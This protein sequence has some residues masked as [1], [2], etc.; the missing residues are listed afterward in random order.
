MCVCIDEPRVV[1]ERYYYNANREAYKFH[2]L[3]M[4][5]SYNVILLVAENFLFFFSFL[6][7]Q[8]I[9]AQ[10]LSASHSGWNEYARTYLPTGFNNLR[11]H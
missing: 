1:E 9:S 3:C 8:L 7:S 2:Y 5:G 4:H 10:D 11:L 6:L